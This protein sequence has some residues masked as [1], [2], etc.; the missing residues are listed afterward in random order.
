MS[1]KNK[2]S[3]YTVM[4][5]FREKIAENFYYAILDCD[6]LLTLI[7]LNSMLIKKEEK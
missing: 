4:K 5:K 3:I 7:K 6:D 1:K 2:K